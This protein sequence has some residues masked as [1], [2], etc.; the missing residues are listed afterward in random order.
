[1]KKSNIKE[2]LKEQ[3][4]EILK[5]VV[6]NDADV[7]K[8]INL[9]ELI[10]GYKREDIDIDIDFIEFLLKNNINSTKRT[11]KGST[12]LELA[13]VRKDKDLVELLIKYGVNVNEKANLNE[14]KLGKIADLEEEITIYPIDMLSLGPLEERI[15]ILKILIS[16]GAD[17]NRELFSLTKAWHGETGIHGTLIEHAIEENNI[18]LTK[19]LLDHGAKI[20]KYCSIGNVVQNANFEF[21]KLLVE[22]GVD[23]NRNYIRDDKETVWPTN[24]LSRLFIGY[25]RPWYDDMFGELFILERS[26]LQYTNILKIS[27]YLIENGVDVNQNS[28]LLFAILWDKDELCKLLIENGADVNV[29]S[30]KGKSGLIYVC[31]IMARG[32]SVG[33]WLDE[34]SGEDKESWE[35]K[36]WED[37]LRPDKVELVKLLVEKGVDVNYKDKSGNTALMNLANYDSDDWLAPSMN[38]DKSEKIM[39][40]LLDNGAD[41]N[42]RNNMG[43]SA[44]MIYALKGEDRLVKILVDRGADATIKSEMTAFDLAKNDEIKKIIQ[45]KINNHPQK[46]IKLLKNFTLD[47]PIKYST[48]YWDFTL[49]NEYKDFD[50]FIEAMQENF[51]SIEDELKELAPNLYK[52]IYTFLFETNPSDDYSWCSKTKVNIGWSSIEGLREHCNSGKKPS[53]F[54]LKKPIV[55]DRKPIAKNFEDIINLFKQE[56]EIRSDFKNLSTIF[57]NQ[58][59]FL[60]TQFDFDPSKSKLDKQFYADTQNFNEAISIIFQEI[61]K[62]EEFHHIEVLTQQYDDHSIEIKIIQRGSTSVQTHK[63]VIQKINSKGGD[64]GNIK[65]LLTNLCDRSIESS[66]TDGNYRINILHS[67]NIKKV[68]KLDEKSDG[69]THILRFYK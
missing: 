22:N 14:K 49:Q 30:Q 45:S 3:K 25:D 15:D 44:L 39:N 63:E 60:G 42:A 52:K 7:L 20:T 35:D 66:F 29:Y 48:H 27:K 19:Y 47:K 67:N 54:K 65:M 11:K 62:R 41:I 59:E 36:S 8:D 37:K 53:D 18:E 17:I 40:I 5:E 43:M 57:G 16:N 28:P 50:G 4:I 26:F 69:F 33:D 24:L 51:N 10:A 38:I 61:K 6:A 23:L 55:L 21:I 2:I 46:L 31:E 13:I 58:Q 12:V 34:E 1:M 68:Q 9:S 56:I 64:M 32:A